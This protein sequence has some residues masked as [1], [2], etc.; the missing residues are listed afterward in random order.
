MLPLFPPM[1]YMHSD[2]LLVINLYLRLEYWRVWD[3]ST[4]DGTLFPSLAAGLYDTTDVSK[5]F[6]MLAVVGQQ[7]DPFWIGVSASDWYSVESLHLFYW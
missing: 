6:Q 5:S 1:L 3:Y 7:L 2:L 4:Q